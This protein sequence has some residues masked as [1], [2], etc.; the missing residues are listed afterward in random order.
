MMRLKRNQVVAFCIVIVLA[1]LFFASWY[2]GH[3]SG[4]VT[5][6]DR[7]K[8]E[9]MSLEKAVMVFYVRNERF[10]DT[11]DEL[12]KKGP[13]GLAFIKVQ[14]HTDP[15]G[16]PFHYDPNQLHPVTKK[17]LIWTDGPPGKNRP[18]RNWR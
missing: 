15:W 11:L 2:S 10:P 4:V 14:A 16:N 1:V 5:R 12:T 3:E 18:V 6:D 9:V 8:L 17:P 7:A 13:D